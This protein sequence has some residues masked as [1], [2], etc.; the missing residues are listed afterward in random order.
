ML[1]LEICHQIVVGLGVFTLEVLHELAALADLFDQTAAGAEV[2]LMR[3]QVFREIL[4]F[5]RQNGDLDLRR[6]GIG[7]VCLVLLN[8]ALLLLCV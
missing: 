4:D 2:L 8:D 6:T 5:R 3:F 1:H 7:F